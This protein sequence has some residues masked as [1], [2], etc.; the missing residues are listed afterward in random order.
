MATPL[1]AL[2]DY[3]YWRGA[4]DINLDF[5]QESLRIELD[6][7]LTIALVNNSRSSP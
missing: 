5:L 6:D 1:R 7:L 2:L 3:V 4:E